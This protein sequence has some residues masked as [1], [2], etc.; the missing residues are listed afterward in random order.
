[1]DWILG[2]ALWISAEGSSF[3]VAVV[4]MDMVAAS[5][6]DLGIYDTVKIDALAHWCH[7]N[8]LQNLSDF[9][10]II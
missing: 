2:A 1:M 3:I 7:S 5:V 9:Q 6:V 4:D 10:D 8:I